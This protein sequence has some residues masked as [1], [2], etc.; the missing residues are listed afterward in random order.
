MKLFSDLLQFANPQ[1]LKYHINFNYF[2]VKYL[3]EIFRSLIKFT[4]N[5]NTPTWHGVCLAI[6]MF[7]ASESSS[8]LLNHYYYLMYRVGTRIQSVLTAA[9]YRKVFYI[10]YVDF[11]KSNNLDFETF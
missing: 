6:L 2:Y 5:P 11:I 7:L 10:L 4:E 9:V 8:L 1:L 3:F